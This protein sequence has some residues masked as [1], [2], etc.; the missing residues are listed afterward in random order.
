LRNASDFYSAPTTLCLFIFCAPK[1]VSISILD[2][3]KRKKAS[4]A[5]REKK[6]LVDSQ[7]YFK[8]NN[9][10]FL[11]EIYWLK[12]TV[13]T[14]NATNSSNSSNAGSKVHFRLFS[15]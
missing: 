11:L 1:K 3:L 7:N 12:A 5:V 9:K 6:F 13:A 8:Q 14:G 10:V 15:V 4:D 2:Y